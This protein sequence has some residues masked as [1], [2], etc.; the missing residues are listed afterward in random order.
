M[1]R[2]LRK[3]LADWM[4]ASEVDR[5]IAGLPQ[6]YRLAPHHPD[7]FFAITS[8]RRGASTGLDSGAERKFAQNGASRSGCMNSTGKRRPMAANGSRLTPLDLAFVFDNVAKSESMVGHGD[9]PK[10]LAE[11]MSAAWIAFARSGNPNNK[12]IPSWAPFRV[13]E[14]ATMVFDVKSRM[15]NDFQ[16]A[17]VTD[18]LLGVKRSYTGSGGKG[19][20]P[21]AGRTARSQ[22]LYAHFNPKLI[23]LRIRHNR[24]VL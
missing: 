10:A 5:V 2:A 22:I 15:V 18:M 1:K 24:C 7:L 6:D 16:V 20:G 23:L 13:P 11:Q 4:P 21:S 12:A 14:R 19:S 3:R 17:K 8:A 9:G